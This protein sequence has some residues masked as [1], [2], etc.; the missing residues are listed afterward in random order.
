MRRKLSCPAV[1]FY[2]ATN[3]AIYMNIR[4][5]FLRI[6]ATLSALVAIMGVIPSA[7]AQGVV[8]YKHIDTDGRVTYSNSPIK[9]AQVV[10]L[11]PLMTMPAVSNRQLQAKSLVANP[12]S[13]SSTS[14]QIDTTLQTAK[15]SPTTNTMPTP[16]PSYAGATSATILQPPA[17]AVVSPHRNSAL[18]GGISAA[19]LAQQRR[20]DVR[21]R[22]FEGEVEAEEQ[23]LREANDALVAE[24]S[25]SPAIRALHASLAS[26]QTYSDTLTESKAL[27]SR[28]FERVRA[29]QDQ[30]DMHQHNLLALR[31]L[32]T[33][34]YRPTPQMSAEVAPPKQRQST[35]PVQLSS[36]ENS[37]ND[38]PVV[39]L[40]PV[41]NVAN[42]AARRSLAEDR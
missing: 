27:I 6:P 13:V 22:I 17:L 23:L 8:V 38:L 30:V 16:V 33:S 34:G 3:F 32:F 21:R 1:S 26:Q 28:H 29:L 31:E 5:F 25:R 2:P 7:W 19:T 24:Q 9:G 15:L 10:E 11:Q 42:S 39:K 35:K 12:P 14:N 40:K 18:N 41:S 4:R 20:D 37:R 36:S